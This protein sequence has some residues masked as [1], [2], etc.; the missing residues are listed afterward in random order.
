MMSQLGREESLLI[1]Y[2][3]ALEQI[4]T[5]LEPLDRERIPIEEALGRYSARDL[6][7]PFQIP[8]CSLALRDGF[9]IRAADTTGAELDH[10]KQLRVIG[11]SF[12]DTPND[13]V[14]AIG[15]GDAV[16]IATGAPVPAGADAVLMAEAATHRGDLLFIG[17]PVRTGSGV[18]L[19]GDDVRD[20]A[21]IVTEG[22]ALSPSQLGLLA[23]TGLSHIEVYRKPRV[24]IIATGDEIIAGSESLTR[25]P[26]A[27]GVIS[28]G[29]GHTSKPPSNAVALTAWCQRFGLESKTWVAGDNHKA[30]GYT[31]SQAIA[32]CDAVVTIGGTGP[33]V[34][35]LVTQTLDDQGWEAVI[36]GVRLR[37]GRRSAFGLLDE[38]PVF[39]LP[40]TPTAAEM[41]FLL[42]ALPGLMRLAGSA[43]PPFIVVPARLTRDL[44]RNKDARQWAQAVRVRLSP[45]TFFLQAT[46][47]VGRSIH[48][49]RGRMGTAALSHG[50]VLL[51]EGED[52]ARTGDVVGVLVL[53]SGW[54]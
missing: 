24:A 6:V 36:Q 43:D 8:T 20:G 29:N 30:L 23:A 22:R 28:T 52:T 21:P 50:L 10:L 19:P 41:A 25:G 31:F 1:T 9:A 38:T 3:A 4:Q 54:S 49:K 39:L 12:P 34:R 37:P 51:G 5:L 7:A 45:G 35:D 48:E 13:A 40:G 17:A 16:A 46:P 27:G 15:P 11:Q 42:I 2:G 53:E 44:R 14:P 26:A 32:A 33:G 18:L 47:L